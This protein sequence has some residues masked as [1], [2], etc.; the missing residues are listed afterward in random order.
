MKIEQKY[1][2]VDIEQDNA[3]NVSLR[4][5]THKF[6]PSI[7]SCTEIKDRNNGREENGSMWNKLLL[8]LVSYV[9]LV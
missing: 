3:M 7:R 1:M 9:L 8:A 2:G 4:T 6:T 5:H